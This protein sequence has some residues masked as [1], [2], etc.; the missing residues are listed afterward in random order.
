MLLTCKYYGTPRIKL[1][2]TFISL[3]Y[4]LFTPPVLLFVHENNNYY[5][6]LQ[7]QIIYLNRIHFLIV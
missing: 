2:E 1:Y 7:K 3:I 5:M 6:S 4:F